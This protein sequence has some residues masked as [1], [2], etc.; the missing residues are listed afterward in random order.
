MVKIQV[1]VYLTPK[2]ESL[3]SSGLS[4]PLL[5]L[6]SPQAASPHADQE[7]RM[8]KQEPCYAAASTLPSSP[9][10]GGSLANM[11]CHLS[12]PLLVPFSLHGTPFPI[13]QNPA[14]SSRTCTNITASVTTLPE[15][16]F[17]TLSPLP[18]REHALISVVLKM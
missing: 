17:I 15:S 10:H 4:C 2:L 6:S 5:G 11:H 9:F 8:K 14:H 16:N 3:S 7:Q 12:T 1:Q 18:C 13:L